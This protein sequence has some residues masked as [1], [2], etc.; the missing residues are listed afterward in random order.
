MHIAKYPGRWAFVFALWNKISQAVQAGQGRPE[1]NLA[2]EGENMDIRPND[3]Y[4]PS[5]GR[6]FIAVGH[7]PIAAIPEEI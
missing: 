2:N 3:R 6:F 7:K 5:G 4:P 1:I